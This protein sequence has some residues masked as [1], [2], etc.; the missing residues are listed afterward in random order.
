MACC[1]SKIPCLLVLAVACGSSQT[2][3]AGS[4][5]EG[6]AGLGVS[7]EASAAASAN[8]VTG[9]IADAGFGAVAKAYWIGKPG[10]GSLPT[11][12]YLSGA[13][14]D[15]SAIAA[16]LWDKTIGNEPLLELGV[17]GS[18]PNSYRVGID[19]EASYLPNGTSA[20]NPSADSGTVAIQEVYAATN[21]AGSF[22]LNFG[23]DTLTGSFDA[24]YCGNGVE[25]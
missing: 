2:T 19:A 22:H 25:P 5:A 6:D 18:T 24:A 3:S 10:A 8:F 14:L 7:P 4:G 17:R 1:P 11:Q 23:A 21:I 13:P 15:C 9:T 12:I 20:F 16:P